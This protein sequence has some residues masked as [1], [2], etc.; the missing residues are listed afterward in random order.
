MA[1]PSGDNI[2]DLKVRTPTDKDSRNKIRHQTNRQ[3]HGY[4]ST[5]LMTSKSLFF[6]T[7]IHP[8]QKG[9]ASRKTVFKTDKKK[10]E[11]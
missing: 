2:Y 10:K 4:G 11:K 1:R 5:E 8:V 6:R 3:G 9:G 7:I